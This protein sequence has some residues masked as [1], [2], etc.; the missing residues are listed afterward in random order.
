MNRH[1]SPFQSP[2][3]CSRRLF[4]GR[5]PGLHYPGP[6]AFGAELSA[7][8]RRTPVRCG[9]AGSGIDKAERERVPSVM[10]GHV[11]VAHFESMKTH[12][13]EERGQ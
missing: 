8:K 2:E 5:C 3:I 11:T 7:G 10:A 13:I 1:L 9:V 6:F 12:R 4:P